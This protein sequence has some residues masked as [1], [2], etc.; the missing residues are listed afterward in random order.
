VSSGLIARKYAR[1]LFNAGLSANALESLYDEA[2][3][4]LAYLRQD[5]QLLAFLTAPQIKDEHKESVVRDSF[6]TRVS[7]TFLSFLL[8][9]VRK[10][11]IDHLDSILDHFIGLVKEHQGILLTRVVT[12]F[13]LSGADRD[14]ISSQLEARTGKKIE[15]TVVEDSSLIGGLI[16]IVGNQI[17]D[18]SVRHYL[19]E[20]KSRL[21]ALKV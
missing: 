11:R 12:A 13:P 4:L 10:H 5:R 9:L 14:R 17:M 21:L 6:A 1:G 19:G 15:L 16:V 20:L 2:E 8:L 18:Y 7:G 3:S